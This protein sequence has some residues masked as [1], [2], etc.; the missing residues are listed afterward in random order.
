M[1]QETYSGAMVLC[2]CTLSI[3]RIATGHEAACEFVDVVD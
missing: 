3:S 2:R 1:V